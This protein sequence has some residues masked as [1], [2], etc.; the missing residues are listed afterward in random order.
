METR[1]CGTRTL[2]AHDPDIVAPGISPR[3]WLL[4][5]GVPLRRA[6]QKPR[7]VRENGHCP[8]GC[9]ALMSCAWA[10]GVA[11]RLQVMVWTPPRDANSIQHHGPKG[12]H[13]E[14]EPN[15]N[16]TDR[17][18]SRQD[19]VRGGDLGGTRRGELAPPAL[20]RRFPSL[21][22]RA[23]PCGGTARGLRLRASLGTGGAAVWPSGEAAAP[24]RRG[25]L[26][27][28][29]QDRSCRCQG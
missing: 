16:D 1:K 27:R 23:G 7:I 29:Q 2:D 19:R 26:P 8:N 17:C 20:P 25:A 12:H 13:F 18:R 14:E 28:R 10:A 11:G 15:V 5:R 9:C 3:D 24:G 22:R 6:E 4:R 21:S